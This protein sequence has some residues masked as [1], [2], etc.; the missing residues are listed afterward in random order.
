MTVV[1]LALIALAALSCQIA[2]L[3][4]AEEKQQYLIP[5][6]WHGPNNQINE[7]KE[8][9]ALAKILGRTIVLPDLQAHLWTDQNKEPMLFKE[10]F[11]VAHVKANAD[12]VL[13][14]E[15]PAAL[16]RPEWAGEMDAA[17]LLVPPDQRM[18]KASLASQLLKPVP[19]NKWL[20]SPVSAWRGC[21]PEQVA[22]LKQLVAPYQVLG[23]QTFHGLVY[24]S[25]WLAG[26]FPL[27]CEDECCRAFKQ[28]ASFIRKSPAIYDMANTYIQ[29]RMGDKPYVA[30][31]VRPYPD[32]CVK[33]WT[34]NDTAD[35]TDKVNQY[36]NNEYLLYRFAPSIKHLMTEY[37]IDTAFVMTHPKVREVVRSSLAAA[38]ITPLFMDL[39]DLKMP[40]GDKAL[41]T[42]LTFSLLAMVEEA[43]CAQAKAFVGTKESSMSATIILERIGHGLDLNDSYT[44][45]R[46][47]GYEEKP[48]TIPGWYK[49]T[50]I[51]TAGS[52]KWR[53]KIQ[54]RLRLHREKM[55]GGKRKKGPAT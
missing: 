14:A 34:Q 23:V 33:I 41:S 51:S 28:M 9:L 37:K 15:L 47:L 13:M 24:G 32:P 35:R 53:S 27:E 42:G 55:A 10:L 22:E 1:A 21:S 48:I 20:Q 17:L 8:A 2:K 54:E 40:A 49:A 38:G 52:S 4:A 11:D 3:E 7:I 31:H 19:D 43:V 16:G 29:E 12:A 46:R 36:C 5:F 25:Q 45:F 30:A 6:M 18:G 39:P 44:F 50:N 26:P